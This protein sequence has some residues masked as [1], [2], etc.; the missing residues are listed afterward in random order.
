MAGRSSLLL[1]AHEL[2]I[3]LDRSSAATR[4]VIEQVKDLEF[5]GYEFEAA[6]GS[7]QLLLAKHL[8]RHRDHFEFEGYR[9]IVERRAAENSLVS[10]ATVKLR[11]QR[12][13]RVHRRREFGPD[14]GA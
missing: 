6:D 1:K 11:D 2:G 5:R 4:E 3:E 12:R 13:A 7:L 14:R 10:E 9:V 8:G